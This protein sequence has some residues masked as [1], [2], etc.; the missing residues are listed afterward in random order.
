M[1][2]LLALGLLLGVLLAAPV[3][4]RAD[5]DPASDILLLQDVYYPYQPAPSSPLAKTLTTLLGST[6]AAGF[7]LK[8]ALIESPADLGAVPNMFG[9]PQQYATFLAAEIAFNSR[10][11]L[12]TVMPGGFGAANV[13]PAESAAVSALRPPVAGSDSNALVRS[14][15]AATLS[16]AR[17]AGHPVAA[18]KIPA[19]SGHG[20]GK[21]SPALIF[22]APVALLLLAGA[23]AT[24]RRRSEPEAE[25]KVGPGP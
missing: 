11:P 1:S 3:S 7:E 5:G 25:S 22:G 4:A 2:R 19:V 17:A 18:P 9:K 21:T 20:S 10:T 23:L 15:I 24:L 13:S 12:L 16:L 14:A 8:V 6:K